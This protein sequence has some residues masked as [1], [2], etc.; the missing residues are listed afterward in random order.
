MMTKPALNE[1]V[2]LM[3]DYIMKWYLWQ[4]HSRAWDRERQNAGILGMLS[5]VLCGEKPAFESKDDPCYFADAT[6]MARDFKHNFPW[7]AELS[8]NEI[9]ETVAALKENMD[10]LCITD[11]LNKELRNPQ[12]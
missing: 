2:D 7:L 1:Q 10:R 9:K 6:I 12:Y 4:F 5:A 11:S 8:K 3:T